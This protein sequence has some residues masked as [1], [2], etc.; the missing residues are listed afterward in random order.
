[1]MLYMITDIKIRYAALAVGSCGVLD[2]VNQV[3][4]GLFNSRLDTPQL[5]VS[6]VITLLIILLAYFVY[7]KNIIA[8]WL[9]IVWAIVQFILKGAALLYIFSSGWSNW[10]FLNLNVMIDI[11]VSIILVSFLAIAVHILLSK[12]VRLAVKTKS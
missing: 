6:G 2:L 1:M 4:Y 3:I 9:A 11:I 8:Y 10:V 5:A 7:R 12:D